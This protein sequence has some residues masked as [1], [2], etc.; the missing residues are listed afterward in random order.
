MNVSE[1]IGISIEEWM[2]RADELPAD[3]RKSYTFK[4][5]YLSKQILGKMESLGTHSPQQM[6][7]I[8]FELTGIV[9]RAASELFAACSGHK[10]R[11]DST[12]RALDTLVDST[13]FEFPKY[14]INPGNREI[15]EFIEEGAAT[16]E[17]VAAPVTLA[18]KVINA[19]LQREEASPFWVSKEMESNLRQMESTY[20]IPMEIPVQTVGNVLKTAAYIPVLRAGRAAIPFLKNSNEKPWSDK[21]P[22]EMSEFQKVQDQLMKNQGVIKSF[23]KAEQME[24]VLETKDGLLHQMGKPFDTAN[25]YYVYVML[26][27]GAIIASRN[28]V[29]KV[30]TSHTSLVPEGRSVIVAGEMKVVQG[31]VKLLNENSGHFPSNRV[32]F[33]KWE[34]EQRGT[35]F[36]KNFTL[37]KRSDLDLLKKELEE[38]AMVL[39]L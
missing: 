27:D 3:Q 25:E 9:D 33:V 10:A 19:V 5:Q 17:F 21:R 13:S 1:A 34:L 23:T 2:K 39:P 24:R 37:N 28:M 20:G 35:A 38:S 7:R 15:G 30:V 6:E 26:E 22:L 4:I 18:M 14:K 36:A 16:L 32:D 8:A 29:N 31:A 12:L 11:A